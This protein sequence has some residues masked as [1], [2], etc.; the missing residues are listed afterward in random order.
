MRSSLR[1][2]GAGWLGHPSIGLM[3]PAGADASRSL[4]IEGRANTEQA[5]VLAS[6]APVIHLPSLKA[7][8]QRGN[9][10]QDFHMRVPIAWK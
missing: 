1:G 4:L 9:E 7:V 5:A 10:P 2:G 8:N 6:R 3:F